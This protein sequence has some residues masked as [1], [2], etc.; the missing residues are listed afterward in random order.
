MKTTEPSK[1]RAAPPATIAS[2]IP[3]QDPAEDR[4]FTA[5]LA[6]AGVTPEQARERRAELLE[7]AREWQAV[8]N[9]R[10]VLKESRAD[11][12]RE[13]AEQVKAEAVKA[14]TE[15]AKD[16]WRAFLAARKV[17]DRTVD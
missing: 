5:Y 11:D 1:R 16:R 13:Q 10:K 3:E 14:R 17:K 15:V 9:V 6:V 7:K 12:N 2:P 8:E 4:L